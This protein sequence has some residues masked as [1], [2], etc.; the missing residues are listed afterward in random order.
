M[1]GSPGLLRHPGAASSERGCS[2][3]RASSP[4]VT[5]R[6]RASSHI[7]RLLLSMQWARPEYSTQDA[8]QLAVLRNEHTPLINATTKRNI[9]LWK[10]GNL[11]NARVWVHRYRLHCTK[12]YIISLSDNHAHRD[13][14]VW[15]HSDK[16]REKSA[17]VST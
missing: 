2:A 12:H 7:P 16:R 11:E 15:F 13:D 4:A 9:T 17:S 10:T 6:K 3:L 1:K 14:R 8:E 5:R